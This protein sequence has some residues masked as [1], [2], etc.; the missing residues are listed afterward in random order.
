[1]FDS[2]GPGLIAFGTL[3]L[4]LVAIA[5]SISAMVTYHRAEELLKRS[6]RQSEEAKA[7][8]AR[9]LE[10]RMRREGD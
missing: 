3:V 5:F 6:K 2:D 7:F 8:Y 10:E 4:A 1:M 9:A